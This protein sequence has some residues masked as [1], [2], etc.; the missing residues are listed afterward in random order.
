MNEQKKK[1]VSK[2]K[3][4]NRRPWT[5]EEIIEEAKFRIDNKPEWLKGSTGNKRK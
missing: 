1:F 2:L 3:Y 5:L 4:G